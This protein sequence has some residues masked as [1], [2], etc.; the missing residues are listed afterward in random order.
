MWGSIQQSARAVD[1]PMHAAKKGVVVL[2]V[3]KA[4]SS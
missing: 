1:V 3:E 4:L 2:F